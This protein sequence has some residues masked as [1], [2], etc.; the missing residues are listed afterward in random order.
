VLTWIGIGILV[1]AGLALALGLNPGDTVGIGNDDFGRLAYGVA[2]L[3]LVGGGMAFGRRGRAGEAI[4]QA[5]TWLGIALV[6]VVVYSYRN[7]FLGM[8]NRVVAELVP[9]RARVVSEPTTDGSR[10]GVVAITAD[11]T[12]HF[13]VAAS[14]NG[15]HVEMVADTGATSVVLTYRDA[16]RAGIPVKD[17]RFTIPVGT[18]NGTTHA[19]ATKIDSLSVGG[20]E[21]RDVR[22]M[23]SQPDILFRSL[24]GM[25]YLQRIRSFEMSGNQLILRQ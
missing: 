19:A 23:V 15:T 22:A 14:V 1:V 21:V 24:L 16:E 18:A 3:I 5:V 12:G 9:G 4:K 10:A 13:N 20:I 17:L 25:T 11:N 2:L 7:E 6:L 8:A